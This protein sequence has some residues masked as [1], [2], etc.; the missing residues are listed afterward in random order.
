MIFFESGELQFSRN[1]PNRV[2]L[3]KLVRYYEYI[4][5]ILISIVIVL[6]TV[7]YVNLAILS[8]FLI[9]YWI[10]VLLKALLPRQKKYKSYYLH[11]NTQKIRSLFLVLGTTVFLAYM[12]FG[13]DYL[14]ENQSGG[15]LWLLYLLSV[16]ISSQHGHT[17]Q[18]FYLLALSSLFLVIIQIG[19]Y[20]NITPTSVLDTLS[21]LFWL[22]LLSIML[23]ILI[24]LISDSL[25]TA[26][27]LQSLTEKIKSK[28]SSVKDKYI[29]LQELVDEIS[30]SFGYSHCQPP[31][32]STN[33][34]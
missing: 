1:R 19:A 17:R 10:Y 25:A 7:Q 5:A 26:T 34:K 20:G 14:S 11:S 33:H 8:V 23:H 2:F 29:F 16:F 9:V 28:A 3:I 6:A 12:Y 22:F 13:T 32:F 27:L 18:L 15:N 30:N 24:K 4:N 31:K 21:K